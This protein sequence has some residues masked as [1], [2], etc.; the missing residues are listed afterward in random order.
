[1]DLTDA[2]FLKVDQALALLALPLL[3]HKLAGHKHIKGV[4]G[5]QE[6]PEKHDPNGPII[7]LPVLE[8]LVG[9]NQENATDQ[10]DDK[11]GKQPFLLFDAL[12]RMLQKLVL[13]QIY[14]RFLL[15]TK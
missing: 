4:Q 10:K 8:D 7:G 14:F 12:V 6:R 11:M 5:K 13:L 2:F 15:F 9:Q 3:S 1:M